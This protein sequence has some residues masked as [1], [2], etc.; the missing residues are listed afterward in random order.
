MK[1]F[2]KQGSKERLFEMMEKVNK[3]TLSESFDSP[4]KKDKKYLDK[5][6]DEKAEE[7]QP[8]KYDDG[9][10][11]P[12]E[13]QLKVDDESLK[14]LKGDDAPLKENID[15]DIENNDENK[16][17][18]LKNI[19]SDFLES[20]KKDNVDIHNYDFTID[21][22][23]GNER[24]VDGKWTDNEIT[25]M[26]NKIVNE[27]SKLKE[28]WDTDYETPKSERGKYKGKTL[29]ALRQMLSDLKKSGP[30]K[31][32]SPE[33]EKQNELEFAIRA[34]TDWGKVSENEM[35]DQDVADQNLENV[36]EVSWSGIKNVGKFFSNKVKG[37]INNIGDRIIELGDDIVK[38]YHRGARNNIVSSLEQIANKFGDDFGSMLAKINERAEKAGDE[39]I[40]AKSL[41]QTIANGIYSAYSKGGG[42]SLSKYKQ[43]SI[44]ESEVEIL[45]GDEEELEGGLADGDEPMEF[46]SQQILKGMEI[47]MRHHTN[48]P[49]VALE[50]TMDHLKEIPDYYDK[51]EEDGDYIDNSFNNDELGDQRPEDSLL[52]PSTHW[53]DDYATKTVGEAMG[54]DPEVGEEKW[55]EEREVNKIDALDELKFFYDNNGNWIPK[56]FE[57]KKIG[58]RVTEQPMGSGNE[59]FLV[60]TLT[61]DGKLDDILDTKDTWDEAKSSILGLIN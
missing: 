48:D 17:E 61:P 18:E 20:L 5:I 38:Q 7:K 19:L 54:V 13:K 1:I 43:E 30:H 55:E 27:A 15:L 16:Y 23:F 9:V 12:V 35:D 60:V 42:F 41:I 8:N 40:D 51:F 56:G 37:V 57:D 11:Y 6:G 44:G 33:Y 47:E 28:E 3:I 29:G 10:R 49:K 39:P 4:E 2:K 25:E 45:Q 26:W 24:G 52:D 31:K 32:G 34:K 59:K 14:G 46:D 22:I 58:I 50:I 36:D 21:D 53:I